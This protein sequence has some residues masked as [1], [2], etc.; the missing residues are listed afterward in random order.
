MQLGFAVLTVSGVN[1]NAAVVHDRACKNDDPRGNPA[2]SQRNGEQRLSSQSDPGGRHLL[3]IDNASDFL[4]QLLDEFRQ[5]GR[6]LTA[7]VLNIGERRDNVTI[8][9]VQRLFRLTIGSV[10]T[11]PQNVNAS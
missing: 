4:N 2:Q 9:G 3:L 6:R 1:V 5:A 8:S 7:L 11:L 10:Q